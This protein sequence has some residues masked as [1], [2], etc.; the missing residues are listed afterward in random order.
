MSVP[1]EPK[2]ILCRRDIQ[3]LFNNA[4]LDT[5]VQEGRCDE[6]I[7]KEPAVQ[8]PVIGYASHVSVPLG[9]NSVTSYY[10][11]PGDRTQKLAVV[12]RYRL[13]DGTTGASRKPDPKMVRLYGVKFILRRGD[14]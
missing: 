5:A 9:S 1:P 11:L 6:V 4:R 2:V 10:Y 8:E 12:H 13:P 3:E 14:S 7:K